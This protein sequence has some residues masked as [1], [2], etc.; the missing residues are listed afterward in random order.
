MTLRLAIVEDNELE[1]MA[2]CTRASIIHISECIAKLHALMIMKI[3][4][5]IQYS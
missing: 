2:A 3:T 1:A 4:A 5:K